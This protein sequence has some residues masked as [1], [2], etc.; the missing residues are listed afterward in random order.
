MRIFYDCEFVERG[1]DLPIQLVSIGMIRDDGAE[2]YRINPESL[3]NVSKHPWL[4]VN[5]GPY[6]P[7][8]ASPGILAWDEQHPEYQYVSMSLD[9]LIT[10]VLAFIQGTPDVELWAYYG[11]YDHVVLC[12]LFGS[13]AELPAGVPMFTHDVQQLVEMFPRV[14]LPAEPWK[15]H[16]AMDDARWARDAFNA[17]IGEYPTVAI[18]A[19][20]EDVRQLDII[21]AEIAD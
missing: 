18:S 17:I 9:G 21:D 11:A 1:R 20:A 6:L 7:I 13:M 5:V 16:H 12:Q 8:Q 15:I 19:T 4:S 10:D 3:S 2:L 14:V